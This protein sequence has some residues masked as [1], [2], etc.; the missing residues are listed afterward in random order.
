M[1]DH[2]KC[3]AGLRKILS[4]LLSVGYL[5]LCATHVHAAETQE[6]FSQFLAGGVDTDLASSWLSYLFAGEMSL[7]ERG[8]GTLESLTVSLRQALHIY[9]LSMF[10][11]G[12]FFLM[13][14]LVS[15]VAE[16]AQTGV[17]MGRRAN[18]LWAPIRLLVGIS[19]LI[20]FT[21]GLSL[22]QHLVVKIATSGSELATEGWQSVVKNIGAGVFQPLAPH[23]PDVGRVVATAVEM[24]LCR[25][26]YQLAYT[27][28]SVNTVASLAGTM[29]DFTKTSVG[30]LNDE[31]WSYTNDIFPKVALCGSYSFLSPVADQD[32][33]SPQ[34]DVYVSFVAAAARTSAERLAYQ[35][36][37]LANAAAPTFLV[38]SGPNKEAPADM[39]ASLSSFVKEQTKLIEDKQAQILHQWQ[40]THTPTV[41]ASNEAQ[42]WLSAGALPFTL[43]RQQMALGDL[44]ERALPKVKPPLLGHQVL[45]HEAWEKAA[46]DHLRMGAAVPAQFE[47]YNAIYHHV[48]DGMQRARAWLYEGQVDDVQAILPDQQDL[49]DTLGPYTDSEQAQTVLSRL[50]TTGAVS[51]GVFARSPHDGT[52]SAQQSST[53]SSLPERAFVAQPLQMLAEMGRRYMGYGTWLLGMLSPALSEPA[54]FGAAV[55]F[56]VIAF[57]FWLAG[58]CLLFAVPFIPFFR[59]LVAALGW[60]VA[61][62][63]AVL[64]LPLVALA[65]LYPVGD[66]LAGPVARQAYWLWLSLFIRPALILLGFVGG[67][68]FFFLGVALLNGLMLDWGASTLMP[69]SQAFWLL[70]AGLALIYA[71]A[72]LILAHVAFRGVSLFPTL[73]QEWINTRGPLP[74]TNGATGGHLPT[75]NN[76][77]QPLSLFS[78]MEKGNT[79]TA[80][81]LTNLSESMKNIR[82]G[83]YAAT[84]QD[85]ARRQAQDAQFPPLP[86][87]KAA[88]R[89]QARAEAHAFAKAEGS[90][91]AGG[92][93]HETVA[94][95]A[96]SSNPEEM[97]AMAISRHM[98]PD[99]KAGKGAAAAL[100]GANLL[101][102]DE[103]KLTKAMKKADDKKDDSPEQE[104]VG[105]DASNNPF[106]AD[107]TDTKP[108]K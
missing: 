80:D 54:S 86:E 96:A 67:L 52:L 100:A 9:G 17:V 55:C 81:A 20:P 48:S 79:T 97:K 23:L 85:I 102:P 106:A 63:G 50:V 1:A 22:G 24:E 78:V 30:R 35:V 37:S 94:A 65:H 72:V 107:Q 99:D 66:G 16:T 15:M 8:G 6:S 28:A 68:L 89:A 56:G 93:R 42:G 75:A 84:T 43:T 92:T 103:H 76:G 61:V 82:K 19:L 58:A 38:T 69:Q 34:D 4:G 31:T 71:L 41:L 10:V 87:I 95:A 70:R 83:R 27:T 36:Q 101:A 18:Q 74:E 62:L 40:Q 88:Q 108:E 2:T 46:R 32:Q 26:I 3:D 77:G 11:L 33:N 105:V 49:K 91:T 90:G 14:Q 53:S 7:P 60:A 13:A 73:L 59:F 98:V 25:S 29:Q 47:T 39:K 51:F 104:S 57:L 21:S 44:S 64:S 45:T 12:G 5:C